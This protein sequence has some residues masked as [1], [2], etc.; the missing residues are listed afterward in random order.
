M[1]K[2]LLMLSGIPGSGKSYWAKQYIE[3]KK[4]IACIVSRDKIRFSLLSEEDDYFAKEKQV[5]NL[6]IEQVQQ[7]LNDDRYQIVIADA[8]HNTYKSR[9]RLI[10]NLVLKNVDVIPVCFTTPLDVCLKNNDKRIGREHTPINAIQF[11]SK[12]RTEPYKDDY[13]YKEYWYI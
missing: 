8:T 13:N 1:N 10:R 12:I 3:D 6:F 11:A 2:K 9:M 4:D 7:A 5:M